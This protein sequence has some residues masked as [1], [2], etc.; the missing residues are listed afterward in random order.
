MGG[1]RRCRLSR[2]DLSVWVEQA[3]GKSKIQ[4]FFAAP[5]MTAYDGEGSGFCGDDFADEGG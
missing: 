2:L 5:R 3:T 4:G 1:W